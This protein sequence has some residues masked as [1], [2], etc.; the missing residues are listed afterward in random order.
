MEKDRDVI[1]KRKR[2]DSMI[3]MDEDQIIGNLLDIKEIFDKYNIEHWL[4][5]GTL[6]GAIR[7]GKRIKWDHD[8]D[9]SVMESELNKIHSILP[10]IKEKGFIIRKAPI[11][12]SEFTF[13]K[14]GYGIDVWLYYSMNKKEWAT[15]YYELLGNKV[16]HVLWLLWRVLASGYSNIDLPKKGFKF[17]VTTLLRYSILLFPYKFKKYCAK[18]IKRILIRNNY[19]VRKCAI[20]PKH[21]LEKFKTVQ[22]YGKSFN[23]PYDSEKYLEYKYGKNW[24]VPIKEWNPWEEDGAVK[25]V[26]KHNDR[27]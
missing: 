2:N 21:Y 20:V 14:G 8:A 15:S 25:S 18:E 27:E 5:W 17:R 7:D 24:R 10:E 26:T 11:S 3:Q 1:F 4:D 16:A 13:R 22:F 23:V 19:I 12:A 9:L 6:L